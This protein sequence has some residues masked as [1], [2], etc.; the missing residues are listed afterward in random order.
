MSSNAAFSLVQYIVANEL[1]VGAKLPSVRE[2]VPLLGFNRNQVR[3]G[4]ITLQ[5]LGVVDMHPRA[6]AFVKGVAAEDLN[7][8]FLLFYRFGMPGGSNDVANVYS[9]KTLLDREIF[10]YAA[11]YRTEN[12]LF[13]LEQNLS[14]QAEYLNDVPA[15]VA[16]D[17]D[18]HRGLGRIARN[19]LLDFF[20]EAILVM[21]RPCRLSHLTPEVNAESYNSHSQLLSVIKAK[22]ERRAEELASQHTTVRLRRLR[23]EF[24]EA[25]SGA[26]EE[27]SS[28]LGA[29]YSLPNKRL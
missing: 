8:L 3:A 24:A 23:E 12:D 29:A 22:D 11:R 6:G 10:T 16:A 19:P 18:F 13:A 21:L 9:I 7:T 17:E 14:R 25:G 20:Q 27:G 2:L 15:F 1:S 26:R 4:L 5:A 28:G